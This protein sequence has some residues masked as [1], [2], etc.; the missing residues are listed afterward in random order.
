[1]QLRPRA[2]RLAVPDMQRA[3]AARASMAWARP[4]EG[5]MRRVRRPERVGPGPPREGPSEKPELQ[6]RLSS[7]IIKAA[8]LKKPDSELRIKQVDRPRH[9]LRGNVDK[10]LM[11]VGIMP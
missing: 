5:A 10:A 4:R 8:S 7:S 1:M 11:L 3:A 6:C 9:P 2:L